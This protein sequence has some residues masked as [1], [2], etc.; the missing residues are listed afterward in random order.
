MSAKNKK[1][2]PQFASTHHN[3]TVEVWK[4]VA[5]LESSFSVVT[6]GRVTSC[7]KLHESVDPYCF[8]LMDQDDVLWDIYFGALSSN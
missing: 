5:R 7:C 4:N 1:L 6:F 3:W 2:S 8:L